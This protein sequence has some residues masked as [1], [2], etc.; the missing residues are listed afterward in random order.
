MF[1]SEPRLNSPRDEA[2]SLLHRGRVLPPFPSVLELR[3]TPFLDPQ[4]EQAE[5][6]SILVP[7]CAFGLTIGC[8]DLA[9]KFI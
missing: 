9:E 4:R 6:L 5:V 7:S 1:A 2:T 3:V 8:F